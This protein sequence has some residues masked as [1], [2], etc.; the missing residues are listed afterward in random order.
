MTFSRLDFHDRWDEQIV[1]NLFMYLGKFHTPI[2][3]GKT[4]IS[5]KGK[6]INSNI[7]IIVAVKYYN[8][9]E[10]LNNLKDRINAE[11]DTYSKQYAHIWLEYIDILEN[12]V[13]SGIKEHIIEPKKIWK[14]NEKRRFNK[15]KVVKRIIAREKI[16]RYFEKQRTNCKDS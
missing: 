10:V 7:F 1:K 3:E 4:S 16:R 6:G 5:K 9:D 11:S 14:G 13:P 12:L 8:R 2:R 15:S